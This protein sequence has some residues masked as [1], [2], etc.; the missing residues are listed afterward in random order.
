MTAR[1]SRSSFGFNTAKFIKSLGFQFGLNE[2]IN[3]HQELKAIADQYEPE[4]WV[5]RLSTLETVGVDYA[6]DVAERMLLDV[7]DASEKKN[8]GKGRQ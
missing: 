4:D 2:E 1:S 7:T 6:V 8:K 3:L 5:A